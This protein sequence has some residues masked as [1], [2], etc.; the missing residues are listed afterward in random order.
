MPETIHIVS[1]FDGTGG[2]EKHARA[3]ADLLTKNWPTTLWA[4]EATPSAN[5]HQARAINPWSGQYPRDGTLVFVGTHFMPD[6]W[7][8]HARPRQMLVICN[9]LAIE[10]TFAFLT[11]LERPTLPVARLA[12]MS[13]FVRRTLCLPGVIAPVIIDIDRFHPSRKI[14]HPEFTIGRHSRDTKE[15]HHPADRSLYEML[16]WQGYRIELMGA[17]VWHDLGE[18]TP[19][20]AIHAE[21]SR[22][23]EDFLA[24]LD[25]FIYRTA[26]EA[27]EAGGRVVMEA[28]ASGLPVVA[29]PLGGYAE[30]I[31]DGDNGF[32]CRTQEEFLDR[33]N[34]LALDCPLRARAQQRA[35]ESA[36]TLCSEKRLSNYLEWIQGKTTSV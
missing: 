9:L 24:T 17:S 7:L 2:T 23:P 34:L 29:D 25:A 28:L 4:L 30:W 1:R 8:D 33:I 18:T 5:N 27:P 3:L 36:E 6:T 26:P 22:P 14:A 32:L 31:N 19:N 20:I 16:A 21:G 35:R 10:Q 13:D 11:H 15:K 12:F